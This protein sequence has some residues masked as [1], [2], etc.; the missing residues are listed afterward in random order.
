[1]NHESSA[2]ARRANRLANETSPYLLQHAHNPVDWYPWGPEALERS[3]RED[4]PIFLSVGYSACHWCH[5]MERESF[6]NEEIAARMN[7]LFVNVKVD[8]EERPDIDEIYMKAVQSMTGSG[9]WPMSVFLTPDLEPF[10][11]GTYFPPRGLHGRPGFGELLE[12]LARSWRDDRPRVVQHG[13]R[14]AE[15]IAAEGRVDA[16]GEI[17]PSVLERSLEALTAN[18][19]PLYGGFGGAPKFPHA[20]DLRLMLRHAQRNGSEE[21]RRMVLHTLDRMARG[22]IHDQLGGGFH[23]YSTDERWLIPHFEKMLY[24]N[25]LLVPAYLEAHLVTGDADLA[26]TAQ[27]ACDWALREMTTPAGGFASAQD[28]DSEG[29][30][31]R[32]FVWTP[33]QLE[34]VLGARLGRQAAEWYGVTAEGNFEHGTSALWR[35][36]PAAEVAR[37]LGIGVAEL[38]PAMEEAR[39]R[40]LAARGERVRPA[41]DDKVLAS[42]NGLMISA[43]AFAHQVLGDARHL[44]AARRAA[45]FVLGSMRQSGRRLF[46]TARAGRAH[47]NAGLDDYAFMIQG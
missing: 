18:F 30:E 22:G 14:M 16:R 45:N 47:V 42:W 26:R 25:A 29:E 40:L 44:D 8:R 2:H 19:E 3:R 17:D 6:E 27:R 20:T 34:D 33:R 43:L 32:F 36:V 11:G 35:D 46:A 21:A 12:A 5:V 1:M 38:T 28:A 9:G 41:T 4:R 24:D 7:A 23:R 13:Q 10:F 31:G 37:R 39:T 15:R